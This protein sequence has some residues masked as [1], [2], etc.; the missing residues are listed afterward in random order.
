VLPWPEGEA[1]RAAGACFA[2]WLDERGGAGPAEEQAALAQV[3]AFIEMHGEARFTALVPPSS[4]NE[5]EVPID[6]RTV[7]RAGFRRRTSEDVEYLVLPEAWKSEVCRG[8]DPKWVAD[9]LAERGF[10]LGVTP[11]SR[12]ISERIPGFRRV[13]VYWLSGAILNDGGNDDATHSANGT[14]WRALHRPTAPGHE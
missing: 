11:R 7:N 8:L 4:G 14:E 9:L 12:S 3:R 13:R 5:L 6:A 10:L 1:L 2:A